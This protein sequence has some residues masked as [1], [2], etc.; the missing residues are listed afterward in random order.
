MSC[1]YP[2]KG[3]QIGILPNGKKEMKICSYNTQYVQHEGRRIFDFVP[4]PCGNCVGCHLDYAKQWSMRCMLEASFYDENY[5]VTLTYDEEHNPKTLVKDDLRKFIKKLR[6]YLVRK[7]LPEVRFYA[8]GEYGSISLRCHF[9]IILFNLHL[10]DL[11]FYK[12]TPQGKL[13]TSEFLS[14]IWQKGFVVV[15]E[16]NYRTCGYVARY[17]M[18]KFDKEQLNVLGYEK[19]FILMSRKPGIGF[20]YFDKN[21]ESIYKYDR[22]YFAFNE[23][24]GESN[25]PKYFDRK[26]EEMYPELL[27]KVKS[28]RKFVA[29]MSSLNQMLNTS[30]VNE[31]DY[32]KKKE[33]N[34]LIKSKML[35]RS[36]V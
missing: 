32:I 30:L 6:T 14:N 11:K 12:Y 17:C 29:E 35:K 26:F 34:L 19:E 33:S 10:D 22:I 18:K 9:H 24:M 28:R 27:E 8:S 20:G 7:S 21:K 36:Q 3:F 31:Y 13:Y 2:K 4:I 23:K 16:C 5:F 15:A 25:P 1:F